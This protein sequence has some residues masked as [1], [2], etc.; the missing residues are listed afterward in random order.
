MSEALILPGNIALNS[1][2]ERV[3]QARILA[4][5]TGRR[6]GVALASASRTVTTQSSDIDCTGFQGL[7]VY[8]NISAAPGAGGLSM[9]LRGQDPVTGNYFSLYNGTLSLNSINFVA[10][11][12]GPGAGGVFN[13]TYGLG[14]SG[15]YLPDVA[16]IEITHATADPYTYSVGYCLVA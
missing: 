5:L 3:L 13:G 15:L 1:D 11:V 9:R 8:L 7:I 10:G 14:A 16:R 2:S 12:F 6:R 4:S